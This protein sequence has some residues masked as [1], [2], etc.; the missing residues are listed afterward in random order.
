[1]PLLLEAR[2]DATLPGVGARY[3]LRAAAEHGDAAIVQLLLR[4]RAK[5]DE[6]RNPRKMTAL[7]WAAA[8][9][10]TE[11]VGALLKWWKRQ[12]GR[13][14]RAKGRLSDR[15]PYYYIVNGRTYDGATPLSLARAANHEHTV[16]FLLAA[17]ADPGAHVSSTA[18]SLRTGAARGAFDKSEASPEP[19]S[20]AS[21]RSAREAAEAAEAAEADAEQQQQPEREG[22]ETARSDDSSVS[23]SDEE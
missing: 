12:P 16:R 7:H 14:T 22:S 20:R 13:G 18:R 5:V 9:G 2:A 17:N 8:A 6:R 1:M 23:V 19:T 10:N 15:D 3:P 21:A 11:A 4:A